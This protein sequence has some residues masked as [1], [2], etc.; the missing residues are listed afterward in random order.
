[1]FELEKEGDVGAQEVRDRVN[2]ILSQR[3]AGAE[4]PRVERRDFTRNE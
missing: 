3:P 1:M 4:T 2:R